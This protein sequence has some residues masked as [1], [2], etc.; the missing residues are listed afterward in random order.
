MFSGLVEYLVPVGAMTIYEEIRAHTKPAES[1]RDVDQ[2]SFRYDVNFDAR[3]QYEGRDT[4]PC[5][6]IA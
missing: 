5:I 2:R 6:I 4:R 1:G 3:H